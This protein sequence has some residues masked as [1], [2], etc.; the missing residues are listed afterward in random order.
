MALSQGSQEAKSLDDILSPRSVAIVGVA[1]GDVNFAAMVFLAA[2][3]RFQF[4]GPIYP[5]GQT[6]EEISGLK[7]YRRITDIPGAVEHVI[8]AIPASAVPEVMEDCVAKGVKS[9][10]IFSAG[11]SESGEEEGIRLEREVVGIARKGGIR[12]LGPNCMGIYHPAANF[13][14]G[15]NFP[16][17]SGPVG[18]LS[19]SGGN[20]YHMVRAAA[21]RGIRFSK[22]VSYG[23]AADIDETELLQYF[24]T[25]PETSIIAAYVEGVKDG[26]RFISV[27][28]E[29]AQ[30]K[31]VIMMKGGSTEAGTRAVAS[32]TGAL[33]GS[34]A[35]WDALF[36]QTGVVRVYSM[37]EMV[38]VILA[39]LFLPP[40]LGPRVGLMGVG[41]GASVYGADECI[42]AGLI[43]PPLSQE[44]VG[45]LAEILGGAGI[46]LGNPID[47][48]LLDVS[49]EQ[50]GSMLEIAAKGPETDFLIAHIG[51]DLG[52]FT[53]HRPPVLEAKVEAIINSA[54]TF[55]KPVAIV[56]HTA[57][58]GRSM[59]VVAEVEQKYFSSGLPIYNS[60]GSAANAI[61]KLIDYH[62]R[63][64]N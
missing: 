61:A 17:E 56:L 55:T 43:I 39:F 46:S 36:K 27:L 21:A 19:Q 48:Y 26:R 59:Q 33:A 9:V 14:F 8:V 5:V 2:L 10:Y 31:P 40:P 45:R 12:L 44:S 3:L 58:T 20:S 47:C 38:D 16:T 1:P 6:G 62:Q 50:F 52:P 23:N 29:A 15:Y 64:G 41:G 4:P 63:H 34:D 7:M 30:A 57:T 25:D 28:R 51:V 22:V 35:I 54:K 53:W 18:Y 13:S 11:F 24:A 60:I 49:P 42:R 32:H 37:E